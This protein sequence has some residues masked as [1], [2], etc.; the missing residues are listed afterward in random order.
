MKK[1]VSTFA[2]ALLVGGLTFAEDPAVKIG[3]W[4]RGLFIPVITGGQVGG[5]DVTA[6]A[7]GVSWGGAPRVG[8]T[9]A[10]SSDMIGFQADINAD[11]GAISAGDQ[12]KIWVKPA[13][14][15][16]IQLGQAYDDTLRGNGTFGSFDW[17]RI[18]AGGAGEDLTFNR[19]DTNKGFEV[20]YTTGD[21][22]VFAAA[23]NLGGAKAVNLSKTLLG[24]TQEGFGYTI[25]DIGQIRVQALGHAGVDAVAAFAGTPDTTFSDA[26]GDG[27]DDDFVGVP[28]IAAVAEVKAY[29][30][31]QAAFKLTSIANLYL[32]V[33]L[34]YPSDKDVA[35]Y[36]AKITAYANYAMD[37]AKLHLLVGY[38]APVTGSDAPIIGG[39][40][41]DYALDDGLAFAAD[42]RYQNKFAASNND[43]L[44]NVFAGITKGFSNGLIG[45][46]LQYATILPTT[47]GVGN[48]DDKGG[49]L[50]PVRAE[51][52][53]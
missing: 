21:F 50:I 11:D 14:G 42:L 39:V 19:L 38:I 35:G 24:S 10:G 7:L 36:Q 17:V 9:V 1:I 37:K 22:F 8:F 45:V 47:F 18:G 15:V 33:G 23:R 34:D 5:E 43:G 25:K 2:L 48:P 52:W 32:D 40:G 3:A 30:Q 46:G 44:T 12:Q 20:S 4:G 27:I 13:P 41:L 16:L 6:S 28:A 29:Q 51:Y 49:L 26:N 31:I 53:F